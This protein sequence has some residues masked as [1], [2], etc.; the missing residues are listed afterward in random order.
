MI[1][2]IDIAILVFMTYHIIRGYSA[3]FSKSLFL[4]IRF[5]VSIILTRFT[6]AISTAIAFV[7]WSWLRLVLATNRLNSFSSG[8]I[9]FFPSFKPVE[10][11]TFKQGTK[12]GNFAFRG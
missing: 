6:T 12:G 8:V 9:L 3:G 10:F 1:S 4:S 7:F 11:A 5:I 2:K